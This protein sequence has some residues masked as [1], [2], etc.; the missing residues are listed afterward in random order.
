M[1][2]IIRVLTTS[3]PD[4]LNRHGKILQ[5]HYGYECASACIPDQPDGVHDDAS[6]AV[7]APKVAALARELEARGAAALFISCASDPGLAEARRA[8]RVPVVGAGAAAAAVALNLGDRVGVLG[9]RD[10]APRAVARVL[11]ARLIAAIRPA[12]VTTTRHLME[13]GGQ[14]RALAAARELASAG[15][16]TIALAC[17]GL[18]TIGMAPILQRALGLPVVDP[19]LAGG[20]MIRY[21]IDE[22]SRETGGPG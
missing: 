4:I 13:P 8:V 20:L 15:A 22:Q 7:A 6:E 5:E 17:T 21:L 2:G 1:L 16:D 19:V 10:E 12:G 18:V 3:D 11:G 14:E 9:I